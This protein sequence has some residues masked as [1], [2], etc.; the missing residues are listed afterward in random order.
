MTSWKLPSIYQKSMKWKPVSTFFPRCDFIFGTFFF[1]ETRVWKLNTYWINLNPYLPNYWIFSHSLKKKTHLNFQII[2]FTTV[3]LYV[4]E[5]SNWRILV[6]I[7]WTVYS[8]SS[9][10]DDS[11]SYF[12]WTFTSKSTHWQISIFPY[13]LCSTYCLLIGTTVF[14]CAKY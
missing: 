10:D 2:K 14:G 5:C 9:H 1:L 4:V 13:G 7:F 3:T 6:A 8:L 11:H 12:L